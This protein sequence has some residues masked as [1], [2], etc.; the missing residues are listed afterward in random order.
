MNIIVWLLLQYNSAVLA[1]IKSHFK[2]TCCILHSPLF[3]DH[4]L[5]WNTYIKYIKYFLWRVIPTM[6]QQQQQQIERP[7]GSDY[8]TVSPNDV[9]CNLHC[10]YERNAVNFEI[11]LFFEQNEWNVPFKWILRWD[12]SIVFRG[13]W[14]D[15]PLRYSSLSGKRPDWFH[16]TIAQHTLQSL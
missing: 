8:Q 2:F 10:Y 15:Q 16:Q 7:S 13:S 9:P 14:C 5:S 1:P 3:W 11:T 6:Q 4:C 12:A